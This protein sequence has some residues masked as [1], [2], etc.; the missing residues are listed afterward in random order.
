MHSGESL[1][2]QRRESDDHYWVKRACLGWREIKPAASRRIGLFNASQ[3][4]VTS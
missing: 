4:P 3:N 2:I 1:A